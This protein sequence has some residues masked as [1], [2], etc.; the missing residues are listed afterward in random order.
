M[1]AV[2]LLGHGG[3]EMLRFNEAVPVPQPETG[4]VLIKV[5]ACG[6]NN[7]D[8]KV[9]TGE[10]TVDFDPNAADV[11]GRGSA[12][13]DRGSTVPDNA[14]PTIDRASIASLN[15]ATSLA[16][17]RI[18]GADIVG[19]IV[20]TGPGVP[21][22]RL[23]ERVLVD[24]SIYN[25]TDDEGR[26][27]L[28]PANVDYIGHGRDGGYAEF[29]TV[30]ADNAHRIAREISDA[31]LATFGCST[32]TAEQMLERTGVSPG[33]RVL[34]TGAGGGVGSA[35]VQLVRARGGIPFAV[36]SRGKEQILLDLG[37]EACIVR[38]DCTD[39]RGV[40][41]R[42]AFVRQVEHVTG[43][44]HRIGVVVDQVG[45]T[46][47]HALLQ[48]LTPGGHYITAGTIAGYTPRVNMHA[49]YM[50]FLSIHGSSQGTPEDFARIVGYIEEG[51]LKPVLGGTF[52]LTELARAQE[53]FQRK[54]HVGNLVIIPDALWKGSIPRV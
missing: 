52:P 46:M 28:D 26:P 10:Y 31:E 51:T 17:P 53:F 22:Q 40:F 12:A 47:L 27:A 54:Q 49:L 45:G 8:I 6:M 29:V 30:P 19:R 21:E 50:R 43:G 11:P 16:F 4:E 35:A 48:T 24:F 3:P 32:L 36:T 37:A 9:R 25:G 1:A 14:Y 39:E 13:T 44:S 34:V 15:G 20:A 7:T 42:A 5:H 41:D 23:G 38:Q 33:D 2:Q 18:Q